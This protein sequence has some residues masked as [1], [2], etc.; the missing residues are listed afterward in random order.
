M[1][2]NTVINFSKFKTRQSSLSE[3]ERL[4]LMDYM[5]KSQPI[6]M[7]YLMAATESLKSQTA[8]KTLFDLGLTLLMTV[9][10]NKNNIIEY[11]TLDGHNKKNIRL[12]ESVLKSDNNHL[13]DSS[14]AIVNELP[15]S[16][17]LLMI[18]ES[19]KEW[20]RAES[21]FKKNYYTMMLIYLKT[22]I[23]CFAEKEVQI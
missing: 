19:L 21:Q 16:E 22:I 9:S 13:I 2:Q 18:I 20:T 4:K 5:G 14:I 11:T 15:D 12:F 8:R 10:E 23:D 3:F 7:T 1:D 6:V 17:L